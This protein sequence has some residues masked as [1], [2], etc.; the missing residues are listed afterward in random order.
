MATASRTSDRKI[1]LVVSGPEVHWVGD[2]FRVK[3]YFSRIPDAERRL[4]PFL[5]LDYAEPY[6]FPPTDNSRRGVGPHPHRGFE[7]VTLAFQGSVAHHDSTGKGG[8]IGPGDVQ[9]MTAASGI[10]HRE[11]HEEGYA[12]RGGPMQMAQIWVNLPR[13]RKMDPPGYQALTADRMGIVKLQDGAGVVRVIA[14]EFQGV[15]GPATTHTPVRMFDMRLA[16]KGKVELSFPARENTAILVMSGQVSINGTR[17]GTNDFVLF[18]NEGERIALEAHSDAQLLLLNGEPI[19]E[20]IVAYGPFVMT[21]TGE[22][23]QAMLDFQA[24]RF[25]TLEE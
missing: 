4:D 9:W 7:T 8:V 21:T 22:I 25:G 12:R 18:E 3:G 1:G 11:Y 16:A 17:V 6:D 2:G 10:L 24:G 14:G 19:G 5:L 15:R 13:S 23:R 20:P